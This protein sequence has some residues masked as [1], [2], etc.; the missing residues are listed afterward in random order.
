[1]ISLTDEDRRFYSENAPALLGYIKYIE[2][3]LE[4]KEK[5]G[6][7]ENVS[8]ALKIGK[9]I[10]RNEISSGEMAEIKVGVQNLCKTD[11]NARK[12]ME[13]LKD[14]ENLQKL[15][16][17]V[18]ETNP[19]SFMIVGPKGDILLDK[20][21]DPVPNLMKISLAVAKELQDEF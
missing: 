2:Y 10:G 16:R 11:E 6:G 15:V 5:F 14:T 21:G 9:F 19:K 17:E 3:V 20:R 13:F 12:V 1:M 8:L 4:N 18:I 7:S